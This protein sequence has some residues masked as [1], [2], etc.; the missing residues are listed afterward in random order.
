[1]SVAP[2]AGIVDF[3]TFQTPTDSV[4]GVQGQV[5]APLA[6]QANYV[7]TALGWAPQSG[8]GSSGTVTSVNVSGGTTGL[9]FSGGPVTVSGTITAG[10]TLGI[11]NGGTGQTTPITA[12]NAL[13]PSQTGNAGK[14]L[15][16]DGTN[17]SWATA[18]GGGATGFEQIFMLMGA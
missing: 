6:G 18:A 13:A 17:T 7:L 14:Y 11:A 2:N 8:G 1:M 16:T 15:T 12:F 3:G 4:N 10:G 9:T 5:P